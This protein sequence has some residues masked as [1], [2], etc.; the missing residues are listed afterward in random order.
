MSEAIRILV[1]SLGNNKYRTANYRFEGKERVTI[2]P[3]VAEA[4]IEEFSPDVIIVIGTVKSA[5]DAFYDSYKDKADDTVYRENMEYL[6]Q[7]TQRL[8]KD[9]SSEE[10][11][12]FMRRINS[13]YKE[14]LNIKGK[15]KVEVCITKYGL[16][17]EELKDTYNRI[18]KTWKDVIEL[19]G[20]ENTAIDVAFDITHSFRSMPIYNLVVL[21]YYKLLSENKVRISHVYYGN[22]DVSKENGEIAQIVDMKEILRLLDYSNAASEFRNTGSVYTLS[23]ILDEEEPDFVDDEM[24]K[25]LT[26]YDWAV[27]TNSFTDM[28]TALDGVFKLTDN[29]D[30]DKATGTDSTRDIK[31]Y[32][33]TVIKEA[34]QCESYTEWKELLFGEKQLKIGNW[35]LRQKQYGRAIINGCEAMR[36]LLVSIDDRYCDKPECIKNQTERR[37]VYSKLIEK[38]KLRKRLEE[39]KQNIGTEAFE[40]WNQ[41]IELAPKCQ[42]YRNILAHNLV[43]DHAGNTVAEELEIITIIN[44]YYKLLNKLNECRKNRADSKCAKIIQAFNL[45][46]KKKITNQNKSNKIVICG[47]RQL[48]NAGL[49]DFFKSDIGAGMFRINTYDIKHKQGQKSINSTQKAGII[50]EKLKYHEL[51]NNEKLRIYFVDINKESERILLSTFLKYRLAKDKIEASFIICNTNKDEKCVESLNYITEET[52]IPAFEVADEIKAYEIQIQEAIIEIK[53]DNS[54]ITEN[55]ERQESHKRKKD[56]G[57]SCD[58]LTFKIDVSGVNINKLVN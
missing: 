50:Y 40:F 53:K 44:K 18:N 3:F 48:D 22:L 23:M 10:I 11:D 55:R 41:L 6:E 19:S 25:A 32:I 45:D 43:T 26:D 20:G 8:G 29:L 42:D 17:E 36:S 14:H 35:Y 52:I 34:L 57:K 4:L 21:N 47:N 46:A 31:Y 58:S 12:E 13:I 28:E 38:N 33:S 37:D 54:C 5:W 56:D 27:Q 2:S 9:S 51:L 7:G 39:N 49:L 16:T 30:H 1:L 15:P 24:K